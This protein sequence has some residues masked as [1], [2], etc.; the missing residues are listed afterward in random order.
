MFS[1]RFILL[2]LA[3]MI[4][5]VSAAP[6]PVVPRRA[7]R[8]A[9]RD[10][11]VRRATRTRS[12]KRANSSPT[13]ITCGGGQQ[14]T[15]Q[16]S[17]S[18][19]S[20]DGCYGVVGAQTGKTSNSYTLKAT[21]NDASAGTIFTLDANCYLTTA[22]R[23]GGYGGNYPALTCSVVSS[24]GQLNCLGG[25]GKDLFATCPAVNAGLYFAS[26]V[27]SNCYP[28]TLTATLVPV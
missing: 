15:L 27:L 2:A 24:T 25:N 19:T 3:L 21:A 6:S 4:A 8:Q 26:K 12:A 1:S 17:G 9:T 14:F 23:V 16:Y 22:G 13:P 18:G 28:V 5:V 11:L 20:S 10:E 7:V